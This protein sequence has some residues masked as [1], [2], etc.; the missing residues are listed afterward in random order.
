MNAPRTRKNLIGYLLTLHDALEKEFGYTAAQ[1][2]TMSKSDLQAKTR[3]LEEALLDI[4]AHAESRIE[5]AKRNAPHAYR[6]LCRVSET[7]L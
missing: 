7:S 4:P 6:W 1:L 5:S 3:R 2:R